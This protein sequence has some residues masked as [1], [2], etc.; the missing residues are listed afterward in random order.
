M[1][2]RLDA[3]VAE[4]VAA[5]RAE[6]LTGLG[7]ATP[8]LL[9]VPEACAQLGGLSRAMFYK[10]LREGLR[11]VHVGR[12]VLVPEAELHRFIERRLPMA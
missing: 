5:L 10:Q 11:V 8:R 12:R 6:A 7:T 2:A 1:T 4:L 3:A 9:T